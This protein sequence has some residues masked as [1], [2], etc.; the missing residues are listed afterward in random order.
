LEFQNDA[1]RFR[2]LRGVE[3]GKKL[4]NIFEQIINVFY[5]AFVIKG[6]L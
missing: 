4:E 1:G 3:A 2:S 6:S 5:N